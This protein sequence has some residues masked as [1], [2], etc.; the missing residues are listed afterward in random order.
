MATTTWTGGN[1]NFSTGSLWTGGIVPGA[2]DVAVLDQTSGTAAVLLTGAQ[3]LA[4]LTLDDAAATLS[5]AG[6]LF[7][8]SGV[9][10]LQ[11]GTLIVAG[12][13]EGGTLLSGGGTLRFTNL[14]P[15]TSQVV[16]PE[17]LNIAVSGTLDL[18]A[19][20][21]MLDVAGLQT[22]TLQRIRIG[23]GSQ[24]VLLDSEAF[25]SQTIDLAGGVLATDDIDP[26]TGALVLGFGA[27]VTQDAANTTARIGPDLAS[28]MLG[29]GAVFNRGTI[30]ATA[31]TLALDAEGGAFTSP[32]HIGPFTNAGTIVIGAGATVID[33]TNA[34]LA[35]LGT[36]LNTGGLLD[37]K[38]RLDNTG[39]TLDVAASGGFSNL[40][41]DGTVT[42]GTIA[43]DGG[44]LTA[45]AASLQGVTLT[46][47]GLTFDTLTIGANTQFNPAG[48]A[49]VLTADAAGYGQIY[50]DNGAVLSNARIAYAGTQYRV[51]MLVTGG[52]TPSATLDATTTLDIGKGQVLTLDAGSN[53]TLVNNAVINVAAGGRLDFGSAASYVAGGTVNV[54][55]GATVSF[56]G[57]IG[58][59]GIGNI[60]GSGAT[61]VNQ[62]QLDLHGGTISTAG[63]ANFSAF[64]NDGLVTDGTLLTVA[65][66]N[67]NL[68]V[69]SGATLVTGPGV[70][71]VNTVTLSN[72]TL[73]GDVQLLVNGVLA[74]TG[75]TR[76][77]NADGTGPGS[78]ILNEQ[79]AIYVLGSATSLQFNQSATLSNANVL[80][81]GIT[82]ADLGGA[83]SAVPDINAQYHSTATFG[84]DTT[85]IA[86]T[87]NGPISG[88][89]NQGFFVNQG[90][91]VVTTG[92]DFFIVPYGSLT[93]QD[94]INQ[95]TIAIAAGGTFDVATNVSIAS[96]GTVTGP[97][98]LLRFDNNNFGAG[99]Y[100]N[101]GTTIF[102]GGASGAPNLELNAATISGG[103]IVN[104][105]GTF[106]SINY[107][108]LKN[109]AYTGALRVGNGTDIYGATH[110]GSLS[111][112]GG[113]LDS[114]S[115]V[116]DPG[117][118]LLLGADQSFTGATISLAGELA[119]SGNTL[120]FDAATTVA[121]TGSVYMPAGH[122]L[123]AGTILIGPGASLNMN[124]AGALLSP[125][126]AASGTIALSGGTFTASAL[127]TGQTVDLGPLS[128]LSVSRFDPGSTVVF[129]APNTLKIGKGTTFGAGA[130]IVGF[131]V[132]DTLD[133]TGYFDVTQIGIDQTIT[134][135]YDGNT[136]SVIRGGSTTLE[137][138]AIGAG[139][140]V[141]GFQAT[142]APLPPWVVSDYF[143]TYLPPGQTAPVPPG[144]AGA[145]ANQTITD[146]QSLQPFANVAL[147]DANAGAVVTAMVTQSGYGVL[148]APGG[149]TLTSSKALWYDT[150]SRTAVQAALGALVFTPAAHSTAPGQSA[151]TGFTLTISDQ[152]G[153]ATDSTTSVVATAVEDPLQLSGATP[154]VHVSDTANNAQPFHQIALSDPDNTTYT[155]TAT[156]SGTTSAS[157]GH[158]YAATIDSNG[159]F[160]TSGALATVQQAL[161]DLVVYTVANQVPTG[162]STE[163]IVTL[164]VANGASQMVGA[165]STIDVAATGT[166]DAAGL[167][168]A[169]TASG[170]AVS[171]QSTIAPFTSIA[172][173]DPR[174]GLYDTATV[175]L[176]N[177]A[178]GTLSD[179]LGGVVNGGTFTV[180]ATQ[181]NSGMFADQLD[182][183]LA[184]L[185]FTPAQ[186]QVA[187]G[188][189]VTTGFTLTV[190]NSLGSAMDAATSVIATSTTGFLSISGTRATQEFTS[191]TR[192]LPL[193]GV[194][195]YDT[196]ANTTL[197]ATVTLSN[198]ASGALTAGAGGVVGS[199][200]TFRVNGS[201]AQVQAAL[202]AVGF[203][204]GAAAIGQVSTSG[205][206]I[207]LADGPLTTTDT[208]TS[209]IVVGSGPVT[210]PAPAIAAL[211]SSGPA[212]A[213]G[214]GAN[215]YVLDLGTVPTGSVPAPITLN[216]LN[217]ATGP[218]DA[219]GGAFSVTDPG[220]FA[221]FG[222]T[223]FTGLAAG[224]ATAA[225]TITLDTS[226]AGPLS[227]T[228][229]FTP[230]DIGPGG[231]TQVQASQTVTVRA[232]VAPV[233]AAPAQ[234]SLN[235]PGTVS[236][237]NVLVGT[238]ERQAVS[239]SNTATPPADA[240]DVT[241]SASGGATVSGA[242][243]GLAAG[244][245]DSTDITLGLGTGTAGH[246]QGVV[247]LA[248]ASA[249]GGT[250]V[251]LAGSPQITVS[252][253]VYRQAAADVALGSTILH[254]GDS[255]VISLGVANTA[256]KDGYSEAL[257]AAI[258]ATSGAVTTASAG[259]TGDIM[260]GGTNVAALTIFLPT[261]TAGVE[262]GTATVSLTS[263]GGNGNGSID[264]L[265]QSTLGTVEVPVSV[266]VNNYA[267]AGLTSASPKLTAG[268]TPD[269]YVLNLGT[270]Q[271]G[272]AVTAVSLS[273]I[274]AATGLADGLSGT[275]MIGNAGPFLN[276]GFGAF[277]ALAAGS[278]ITAGSISLN[279]SQVGQF[280]EAITFTPT[281]VNATGFTLAQ[282]PRT[283]TVTADIT[284]AATA[285]GDVHMV[286]FDGLRYDFQ[287][288]GD[289]TLARST[290]AANPFAVQIRTGAYPRN[291]LASI[292]TQ[293]AVEIGGNTVRF[294]LDGTVTV[295][296]AAE[297]GWGSTATTQLFAGGRLDQVSPGTLRVTWTSGETLTVTN[298]G[299]YF[300]LTM[301]LAPGDGPGSVQGLLGSD[302]GHALDFQL[303]DGTVLTPPVSEKLLLG[304]FADAWRVAPDRSMLSGPATAPVQ[305][306]DLLLPQS[307]QFVAAGRSGET[308]TGSLG[309]DAATAAA[310]ITYV[311][312]LADFAGD[313][314]AG[315]RV[316]DRIDVTDLPAAGASLAF[317]ATSGGGTLT[318]AVGGKHA[319]FFLSGAAPGTHF[320]VTA[321]RQG[322]A[323]IGLT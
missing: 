76:L 165:T 200:G 2:A 1:G 94:F 156:L 41:L 302:S 197:T 292:T 89:G 319:T 265:G 66:Q 227:E 176:S 160:H 107:G 167:Y 62:G 152:S 72:A 202:R 75:D 175:V 312:T 318:I 278:A 79:P 321:D 239:V 304:R 74:I 212:L 233:A 299:Y 279:T 101:T 164:T 237:P 276:T 311:G 218:A 307:M 209:L 130:S 208:T 136:L 177:P 64:I 320:A 168:I 112:V 83:F 91:I 259:P 142:E 260:A 285:Q 196:Q 185:I 33:N 286:T 323:L 308:L 264:G 105:G 87:V 88:L 131:G 111:F 32:F 296:G 210:A 29:L 143:I 219:L 236:F 58:L 71:P 14:D 52:A 48:G 100:D 263:D 44:T 184:G 266:T 173:V 151:S 289:F 53:G 92:A 248:A 282:T 178:N 171:D 170:Q 128:T 78:I 35:G 162:Q 3:S 310:G 51:Q 274:N 213:G 104:A 217:T 225:G 7:L 46:G 272:T 40:R 300:D 317:A 192:A 195:L 216:A 250:T 244:A 141:T 193:A 115:A 206:T 201:L 147:T 5:L 57:N 231:I 135:A 137:A 269:S 61:L 120:S 126:A 39:T 20:P 84:P 65:G 68:G 157:F 277:T 139:Y 129:Q 28:A 114:Q 110:S 249:S 297:R 172:I 169:G 25:N 16:T 242:V 230:T 43:E 21:T 69:L 306:A 81:S 315:F 13:L 17:L 11:A 155:A 18:S 271:A 34:T 187:R 10:D 258:V 280:S 132:G 47:G 8:N 102:V 154:L 42:G 133:L 31:G 148:S 194:M 118:V 257:I 189:T 97:G 262:T 82:T 275:F 124:D 226:Q 45:G 22:A 229:V 267:V 180:T 30:I 163:A 9:L 67:A 295:N 140:D 6:N 198:P 254:V 146:L 240:L 303:P 205:M 273:A 207:S 181:P 223:G 123:N 49:F 127:N 186:H 241:A 138:I 96:L 159:V 204:P 149:G 117:A 55:P 179:T 283:V 220:G 161:H 291:H 119:D 60:V 238:P 253:N 59:A 70:L 37:L 122:I 232:I 270:F 109:V 150:G 166:K 15:S 12:T 24:L 77:S 106:T 305:T 314:L 243:A 221:N 203:T 153:T 293:A 191:V 103:T 50:L 301:A 284:P 313:V 256:A 261:I 234:L 27:V 290:V 247:T 235:S 134:F 125:E 222:F 255:G 228:I 211:S 121:V 95:G 199:G 322:G 245:S 214:G 316:N 4:G 19:A 93:A 252:G 145:Q 116:V 73:R 281:D 56:S 158:S 54:A 26:N 113:T 144:I 246:R 298:R 174:A 108:T 183:I 224:A 23:A 98:G 85:I 268:A 86:T 38:G 36:I 90:R 287:A 215:S 309:A 188:Q 80:L 190:G 251:P 288:I 294:D 63:N 182:T 99:P